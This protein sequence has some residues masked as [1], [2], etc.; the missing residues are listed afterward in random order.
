MVPLG[1]Y[2]RISAGTVY[3]PLELLIRT[4]PFVYLPF[5]YIVA[6]PNEVRNP[7]IMTIRLKWPFILDKYLISYML[8]SN[9]G[10]KYEFPT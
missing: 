2:F 10:K 4:R 6:I 1:L 8:R 7:G 3:F 9:P 5:T